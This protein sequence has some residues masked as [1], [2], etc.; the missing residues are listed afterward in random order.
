MKSGYRGFPPNMVDDP[1]LRLVIKDQDD[2]LFA[3][4]RRVFYVG[5]TRTRNSVYLIADPEEISPFIREITE[6][7][8][9]AVNHYGTKPSMQ[10]ISCTSCREGTLI[11][12]KSKNDGHIYYS[13]N[14]NP[15]CKTNNV[16]PCPECGG[17]IRYTPE[18]RINKCTSIECGYRPKNCPK[19]K[20]GYL[21][22][23]E[24]NSSQFWGCS[25]HPV[26]KYTKN[27]SRVKANRDQN[28]TQGLTTN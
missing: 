27:K 18:D 17:I 14:M 12:K 11:R 4:E 23:I 6:D 13:C 1:L 26:C 20:I 16:K 8:S 25:N 22:M 10:Q 3:E 9:L 19:C 24:W 2:Y 28:S 7:D 5:L 21:D 15:L